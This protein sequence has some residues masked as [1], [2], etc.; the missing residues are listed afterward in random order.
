M[1]EIKITR[2][3]IGLGNTDHLNH[4]SFAQADVTI[5][6]FRFTAYMQPDGGVSLPPSL[7]DAEARDEIA[8]RLR[9]MVLAEAKT[10]WEARTVEDGRRREDRRQ[11]ERDKDVEIP[12]E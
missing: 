7:H 8:A 4:R 6:P 12:F 9:E 2:V 10:R 3:S 11:W 1:T 5:G